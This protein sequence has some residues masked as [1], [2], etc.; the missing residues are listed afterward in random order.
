MLWHS[1]YA[2]PSF[3]SSL[4]TMMSFRFFK[5]RDVH[6]AT[7]VTEQFFRSTIYQHLMLGTSLHGPVVT[8]GNGEGSVIIKKL[9]GT[10]GFG[11]QNAARRT[12]S[13]RC[14]NRRNF[15]LDHSRGAQ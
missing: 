3:Q 11:R 4:S 6:A 9:R 15:T 7:E 1:R 12:I 14:N 5:V 8:P 13:T 2:E 10:A